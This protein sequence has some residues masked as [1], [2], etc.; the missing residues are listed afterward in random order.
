MIEHPPKVRFAPSPTGLLHLGNLRTAWLNFGFASARG[1]T[2]ILRFDDT[3]TA[4]V[5]ERFVEA[6]REDL[7]WAGIRVDAQVRQSERTA[8]YEAAFEQLRAAGRV[9]PAWE[10]DAQ[11]DLARRLQRASGRPPVYDRAALSLSAAE[12]AALHAEGRQPHWRFLLSRTPISWEDGVRGPQSID[13]SALSDPVIRRADGSFLYSFTSV[14][15]DAALAITHVIRGEDHVTNTAAQLEMFAA[16]GA[17]A[18]VFA[19]HNLFVSADA[20]ALSKREGSMGLAT[21]RQGG[22]EGMAVASYAVL[23]GTGEAVRPVADPAE[24]ARLVDLGGISRAPARVDMADL[25]A[26]N[27]RTLHGMDFAAVVGRLEALGVGGG[28]PFWLAVRGN[29]G[30]LGEA[31][32][33]WRIVAG[34][35]LPT[36]GEDGALAQALLAQLPDE[37]W[38]GETFRAWTRAVSEATGRRGKALFMPLRLAL[39][40]RDA[41]PE[42]APLL[43][44]I[45]RERVAARLRAAAGAQ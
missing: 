38:D 10:R 4:R 40:G 37:P 33:W 39:T 25:A 35:W 21:L 2:F 42:L 8:L 41:G 20:A 7:L 9:Y 13:T 24:L 16:L 34:D 32:D 27:A 43:P 26:L 30:T 44:L 3:D 22:F 12:R 15:D 36:P 45:G 1:G 23:L 5:E 31:A 18:P 28:E 19:H 17:G 14:V 29:L 6:A 11:L